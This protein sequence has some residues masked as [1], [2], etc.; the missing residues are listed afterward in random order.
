[1]NLRTYQGN[2]MAEALEKVKQDLGRDAVILHTRTV[3]RGGLW[4]VGAR[5]MVEITAS[6]D[7]R[8]LPPAERR[9]IAGRAS[10]SA[11]GNNASDLRAIPSTPL[12]PFPPPPP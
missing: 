4:G 1:M 12:F 10:D 9:A 6:S 8:D 7:V 2:S 3:K 11:L 5:T